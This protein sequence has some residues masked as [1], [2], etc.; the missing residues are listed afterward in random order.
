M[1]R[2]ISIEELIERVGPDAYAYREMFEILV[3]MKEK[4]YL[5]ESNI[6]PIKFRDRISVEDFLTR[7]EHY[8][9]FLYD[10]LTLVYIGYTTNLKARIQTH[11]K[12]NKVFDN[13][14]FFK[15]AEHFE[16]I[17]IHAIH[18]SELEWFLLKFYNTKYNK[19]V[20]GNKH[21]LK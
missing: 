11:A 1:D 6:H 8:M 21:V 12:S 17:D 7:T 15:C 19:L 9:Y 3:R 20:F 10:K 5:S 16:K 18:E 4:F 14:A 13:I 2:D